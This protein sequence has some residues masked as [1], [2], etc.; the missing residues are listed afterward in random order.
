[1]SN[2]NSNNSKQLAFAVFAYMVDGKIKN[3]AFSKIEAQRSEVFEVLTR[4]HQRIGTIHATDLFVKIHK[5]FAG[6]K[7]PD[8]KRYAVH[9]EGKDIY[10]NENDGREK[11]YLFM[12]I[13][14]KD[15][16]IARDVKGNAILDPTTKQPLV[17]NVSKAVYAELVPVTDK[18]RIDSNL[19]DYLAM[20]CMLAS[21][22]PNLTFTFYR[23]AGNLFIRPGKYFTVK[24]DKPATTAEPIAN[25]QPEMANA[26]YGVTS[27]EMQDDLPF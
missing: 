2:S 15:F 16:D 18:E 3:I 27:A 7:N 25:N 6:Q 10:F 22:D 1:M 12:R 11:S 4:T 9:A 8:G 14:K 20:P 21:T 17:V 13:S 26:E 24:V 23:P 19:K 5:G